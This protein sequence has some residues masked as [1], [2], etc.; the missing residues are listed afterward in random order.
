MRPGDGQRCRID[1]LH[2][3]AEEMPYVWRTIGFP[4]NVRRLAHDDAGNRAK[5]RPC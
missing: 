4:R 3:A 1:L 5:V 2:D